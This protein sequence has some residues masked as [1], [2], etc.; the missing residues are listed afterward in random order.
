MNKVMMIVANCALAAGS[1]A[2]L[3]AQNAP[4]QRS[5]VRTSGSDEGG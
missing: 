3:P 2:N 1:Y 5:G 4:E